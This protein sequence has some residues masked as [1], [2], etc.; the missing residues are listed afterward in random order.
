MEFH[1]RNPL[2]G[3]RRLT[4]MMLDED[5]FGLSCMIAADRKLDHNFIVNKGDASEGRNVPTIRLQAA[6][7]RIVRHE[8]VA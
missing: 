5:L 8:T 4:F 6:P 7:V 1:D 2:E 3:Y